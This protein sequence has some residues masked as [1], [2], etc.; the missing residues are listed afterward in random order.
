MKYVTPR[1]SKVGPFKKNAGAWKH[2]T[3]HA[4]WCASAVPFNR[5]DGAGDTLMARSGC[6]CRK[7]KLAGSLNRLRALGVLA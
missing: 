2:P 5:A 3:G 1:E 6:T 4:T 7:N